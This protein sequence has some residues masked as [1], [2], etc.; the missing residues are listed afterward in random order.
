M[1]LRLPA[2]DP[3]GRFPHHLRVMTEEAVIQ[4]GDRLTVITLVFIF[5]DPEGI[6]D[7]VVPFKAEESVFP[8]SLPELAG[9]R[10]M[11]Q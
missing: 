4:A 1:A 2:A 8:V 6:P 5:P 3:G 9:G 7:I 11:P 10:T